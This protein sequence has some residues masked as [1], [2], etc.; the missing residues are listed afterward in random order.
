MAIQRK[1]IALRYKIDLKQVLD[2]CLAKEVIDEVSHQ[3]LS[4][5][6]LKDNDHPLEVISKFMLNN[7]NSDSSFFRLD[8][9]CKWFAPHVGM[10]YVKVDPL[11]L[12]MESLTTVIPH[13]YAYRL[14]ILPI[15]VDES[16]ITFITSDPFDKHW[17]QDIEQS[18][19]KKIKVLFS[20]PMQIRTLL[21]EIFVIQK[22]FKDV[23][24]NKS[25]R[26]RSLLKSG[27]LDELNRIIE[28]AQHTSVGGE[29]NSVVQVVDWLLNFAHM[30]R[31]SDIH[32]EPKRGMGHIRFRVDGKLRVVQTLDPEIISTIVARFKI[33]GKLKIDEKRL[34]QDGQ[35]I[36]YIGDNKIELR[37]ST[38][39]SQFGEKLVVRIFDKKI[40]DLN[41]D[42][43]GFSED[44]RKTWEK[45]IRLPQ[46]LILVTGPT[47]S[48]K[49]TTLYS[50]LSQVSSEEINVCSAEDPIEMSINSMN[51]VQV[52]PEIGLTFAKCMKSFLRQDP[53]VIMVGE[54]RDKE[55]GEM[56][57]QASLTGHLV[58]S[59]VHTNGALPTI[60]RLLD[61]GIPAH[62]VNS[63][64]T[65]I[66][67]QRL[68]RKL[69]PH[70]KEK[71]PTPIDL[72]K[73][74]NATETDIQMPETVFQP[75]GC[76]NCK[77]TGFIGRFCIYE[78]VEMTNE[79]RRLI[80]QDVTI[81]IL[82]EKTRGKFNSIRKS[83]AQKVIAG[84]CSIE[85]VLKV[86]Y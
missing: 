25:Y 47:G 44:D 6:K 82:Q 58:L 52:N 53:D 32:V 22:A 13:A 56:A 48:G 4:K 18:S 36:H 17:V 35:I 59:T 57:I 86:V 85:E 30:E 42:F 19:R 10:E 74:L 34:P 54:I 29:D 37:L 2:I 79:F 39:P 5:L 3:N 11:R 61:L 65:G 64:L 12:K 46:G 51:Q 40:D 7:P 15:Q 75:V 14:Q 16:T 72:W 41:L 55:T 31:A 20:S 68:V 71:V 45:L 26:E 66:L 73:S 84:D 9:L 38:I 70:C 62:L 50:S 63:S 1:V 60:N 49:S 81:D 76:D 27:K 24:K 69:C 21:D 43:I 33:L 80:K 8:Q 83:A 67:A 23:N 28:R 78:L 77:E